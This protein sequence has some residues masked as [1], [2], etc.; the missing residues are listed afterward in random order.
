MKNR[1]LILNDL[2]RMQENNVSLE[3]MS[4]KLQHYAMSYYESLNILHEVTHQSLEKIS[5]ILLSQDYWQEMKKKSDEKDKTLNTE[6][7]SIMTIKMKKQKKFDQDIEESYQHLINHK[8]A[9]EKKLKNL[10][11]T[12]TELFQK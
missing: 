9:K 1:T 2:S 3:E 6:Y 10:D 7:E 8:K 4:N 5:Q 12:L 11:N